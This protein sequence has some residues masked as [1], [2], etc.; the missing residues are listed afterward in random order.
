VQI[1]LTYSVLE[2]QHIKFHKVLE[3]ILDKSLKLA[4]L[5]KILYFWMFLLGNIVFLS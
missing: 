2:E 3:F 5:N 1:F 4:T